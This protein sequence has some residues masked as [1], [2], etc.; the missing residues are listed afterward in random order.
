MD[1]TETPVVLDMDQRKSTQLDQLVQIIEISFI[2]LVT[3][4]LIA[5]ADTV[6]SS[7]DLYKGIAQDY[8]G[9]VNI[10]SL[11]GGNYEEIV[12]ITLIFNLLLFTFSLIFGLWI[13]RTRDGWSWGD[14]G[15]SLNT[16]GYSFL[17]L[18]RR[19][20]LLGLIAVILFFVV[21]API[22]F[23]LNG[24]ENG[25]LIFAYAKEDGTLFNTDALKAEYYFGVVE[26][27]FIWPLSAGFFFFAYAYNSLRARFPTGVANILSTLFYV[28]YLIFFFIIQDGDKITGLADLISHPL[29]FIVQWGMI[30]SLI[31]V[32]YIN[33]SSFAETKSIVLPFTMNF[34]FN[35]GLTV[36]RSINS[37]IFDAS[38]ILMLVIPV[39]V[40]I[41]IVV[42]FL[43]KPNDFSTIKLGWNHLRQINYSK[44]KLVGFFLLFM[45]LSFLFPGI[46]N[47]LLFNETILDPWVIPALYAFNFFLIILLSVVVLTYEPTE[48]YDVLLVSNNGIPISSRIKL[49]E[50]DDVLISGFFTAIASVDQELSSDSGLK[51]IK[52]GKM[53]I[54][55]EEGVNSR[56]IALVDRDQPSIR[57]AIQQKFRDFEINTSLAEIEEVS[58]GKVPESAVQ[59]VKEIGEISIKFSIPQQTRWIATLAV[60]L[61]PIM[62]LLIGLI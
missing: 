31:L 21:L 15:Y 45:L 32:L 5:L 52:R 28:F 33:F 16:P 2:F 40:V 49:F 37:I 20:I 29:D 46:I 56:I 1:E 54:L 19:G 8:L 6:L 62:M 57:H 51:S 18:V 9:E 47:E 42:W 23:Y 61:G 4:S 27:G 14:L 50:T 35:V 7:L 53:E 30:F 34:V 44:I 24:G 22:S 55:F 48:V 12:R 58:S 26:M 39:S 25:F 41:L 60:S 10:G 43:I 59:L 11:R 3:F 38:D 13:R 17:S 36:I